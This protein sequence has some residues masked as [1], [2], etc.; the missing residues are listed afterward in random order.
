MEVK[1]Q[2]ELAMDAARKVI[3]KAFEEG[4][5]SKLS[6]PNTLSKQQELIISIQNSLKMQQLERASR[7][8]DPLA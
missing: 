6:C 4:F 3:P 7:I 5:C 1:Y 8:D 2:Q